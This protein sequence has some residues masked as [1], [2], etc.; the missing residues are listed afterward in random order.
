MDIGFPSEGAEFSTGR[1]KG[2]YIGGGAK[3]GHV[4]M[5]ARRDGSD[6]MMRH[7]CAQST[8]GPCGQDG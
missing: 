8:F 2:L 7:T 4:A 6:E 5:F 1:L 3:T